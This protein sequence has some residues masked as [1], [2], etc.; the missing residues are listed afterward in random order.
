[1]SKCHLSSHGI[2]F[3]HT[4]QFS[5]LSHVWLFATPWT[6]VR[7]ASLSIAKSHAQTHVHQVGDAIQPCHPLSSPSAPAFNLSQHQGLFQ[8]IS[9]SHQVARVLEFQ[10]QLS[11]LPMNI[12]DWL[13]DWLDLLAVQGTLKSLLQHHSS[14]V[15]I[16]FIVQLSHPYMTTG[17]TI[18]FTR[19]TFVG[20]VISLLFNTLST[21]VIAFL[22]RNKCL[23]I[24]WLQSPRPQWFIS[25][26]K[27][28]LLLTTHTHTIVNVPQVTYTCSHCCSVAS[29]CLM[30]GCQQL[31]SSSSQFSTAYPSSPHVGSTL[32]SVPQSAPASLLSLHAGLFSSLCGF[33]ILT[34]ASAYLPAL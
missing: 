6:A 14:K 16:F 33:C 22:L 10:L 34:P 21:F 26:G 2:Y 4:H 17:K 1:M 23:L 20:K 3:M 7:Q 19:W 25:P 5:S 11:V 32:S 28:I 9:S 30:R 13:M 15:S 27:S 29:G 24:S 18:A 31:F 8:W 12:Q